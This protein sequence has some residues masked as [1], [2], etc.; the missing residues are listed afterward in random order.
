MCKEVLVSIIIPVYNA[1]NTIYRCLESI[2]EQTVNT[3][4]VIVVNDGSTDDSLSVI[5]KFR[6]CYGEIDMSVYSVENSGPSRARNLG[7][8]YA[9]GLYIAFLDSDDYWIPN[10][11]EEQLKVLRENPEIKLLSSSYIN[12]DKQL[13]FV[14]FWKLLFSNYFIT[15]STIGNAEVL[16]KYRFDEAQSFSEDY[17]L[18]L[19]IVFDYKA[20]IIPRE[21][22]VYQIRSGMGYY[23]RN[24]LSSNLNEMTKGI[25]KNYKFLYRTNRVNFLTYV[26][27]RFT[28]RIK[29]LRRLIIKQI[30]K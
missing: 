22:V 3:Y 12:T 25:I 8:S 21:N 14:K 18:W 7:V 23:N 1:Q 30:N 4:E 27:L 15:S 26:L 28:A 9:K 20:A 5:T 16:K 19:Q 13:Y 17:K 6:D 29:H 11:L 2:K 10:K 24:S